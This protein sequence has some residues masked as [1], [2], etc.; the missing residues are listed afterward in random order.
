MGQGVGFLVVVLQPVSASHL[1]YSESYRGRPQLRPVPLWIRPRAADL[2]WV[3]TAI[4]P[5]LS[6]QQRARA[7][8][9]QELEASL[10]VHTKQVFVCVHMCVRACVFVC[11]YV[12]VRVR[13]PWRISIYLFPCLFLTMYHVYMV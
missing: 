8:D 9:G 6:V 4:L 13:V 11:A 1:H 2:L 5:W 10:H 12:C 7:Q 3:S